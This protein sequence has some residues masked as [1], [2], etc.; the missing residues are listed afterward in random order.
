MFNTDIYSYVDVLTKAADASWMR[1]SAISNNL[2]NISTPNYKRQDV[3]FESILESELG[4]SKY[5]TLDEKIAGIH[6]DHLVPRTYTDSAGYSYRV[7]G[8]NVD[9]DTENVELAAEQLR[10]QGLTTS[11]NHEFS[12]IKSVIK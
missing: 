5:T 9:V 2:A 11:I 10:Y 1:E 6:L 12:R 4:H 8:N 3:D 7:D